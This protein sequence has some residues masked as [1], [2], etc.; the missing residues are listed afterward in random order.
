VSDNE[1]DDLDP[2]QEPR[3]RVTGHVGIAA[4]TCIGVVLV[5]AI[6][7][8]V[9]GVI[10]EVAI[11]V[12]LAALLAVVFKPAADR[13]VRRGVRP[14]LAAGIVVLG[15][16]ALVGGIAAVCVA[17]ISRASPLRSTQLATTPSAR[18]R[19]RATST[20]NPSKTRAQPSTNRRRSLRSAR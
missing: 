7:V 8:V 11:P 16:G 18:S 19:I 15:L 14:A 9:F 1:T 12:A 6:V 5:V 3:F 10:A 13:L 20:P 2:V 17:G 4:W